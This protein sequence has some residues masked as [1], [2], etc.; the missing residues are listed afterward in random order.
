M[1]QILREMLQDIQNVVGHCLSNDEVERVIREY[2]ERIMEILPKPLS[3]DLAMYSNEASYI[4]GWNA[5]VEKMA[6]T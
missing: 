5:C 1:E 4:R 6:N 2:S 3:D